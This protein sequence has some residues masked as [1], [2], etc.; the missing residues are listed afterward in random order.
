MIAEVNVMECDAA[1][2]QETAR[3]AHDPVE[4]RRSD[5]F[6][7]GVGVVEIDTAI[8]KSRMGAVARGV[9]FNVCCAEK[10]RR[11]R[12]VAQ[13]CDSFL[14]AAG[15]NKGKHRSN[16]LGIA[17]HVTDGLERQRPVEVSIQVARDDSSRAAEIETNRHVDA[18]SGAYFHH[19][20]ALDFEAGLPEQR[21]HAGGLTQQKTVVVALDQSAA[22][23]LQLPVKSL[24]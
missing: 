3:L 6:K 13:V 20:C 12:Y 8:C 9:V 18:P 16:F 7:N 1:I 2:G 15:V 4:D 11:S 19:R 14:E 10:V 5:V 17:G 21:G 24:F 22:T 23:T